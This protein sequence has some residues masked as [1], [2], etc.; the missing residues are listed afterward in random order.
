VVERYVDPNGEMPDFAAMNAPSV[1]QFYR[2][3]VIN[4]RRFAP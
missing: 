3:R 4:P 2:F 1:D